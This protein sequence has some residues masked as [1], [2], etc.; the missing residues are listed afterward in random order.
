MSER[1]LKEFLEKMQKE[2]KGPF[3]PNGYIDSNGF[4]D[5]YW[6]PTSSWAKRVAP[7]IDLYMA[8]EVEDGVTKATNRP[9]GAWVDL[10]SM[11]KKQTDEGNFD[12]L[13][14]LKKKTAPGYGEPV[15]PEDVDPRPFEEWFEELTKELEEKYPGPP[16]PGGWFDMHGYLHIHWENTN[17]W[18]KWH[19]HTIST[20]HAFEEG[21]NGEPKDRVVGAWIDVRMILARVCPN[22]DAVAALSPN[23]AA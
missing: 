16:K 21:E 15:R 8:Y 11:V 3:Q 2:P 19:N 20:Y 10:R 12:L 14:A 13:V 4:L 7:E 6:D 17:Y 9:V 5:V 1:S 23:T 18:S 22:L